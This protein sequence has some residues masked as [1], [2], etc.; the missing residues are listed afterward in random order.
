MRIINDMP[1]N[2]RVS[3]KDIAYIEVKKRIIEGRLRP[4]EPIVEE[5]I[6]NELGISRTP[7]REALQRLEFETLV[8]RQV[9]G[10]LRVAPVSVKEVN[11]IFHV[12]SRLE[13]IA[14]AEATKNAT[15]EDFQKLSNIILMIKETQGDRAVNDILYY[16]GQFHTYIYEMSKNKT[17]SNLLYQLN[18]HIHRYRHLIPVTNLGKILKTGEEH[19]HI[20]DFMAKG[21]KEGAESAM[22][23]HILSS[24]DQVIESVKAYENIE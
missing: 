11:E 20:L 17:V 22:V 16:G 24:L 23:G 2:R 6:S 12:R 7:L 4:G 3:T 10:R 9:N 18:D 5:T 14:V 21:D 8:V 1:Q 15:E 19:Q 13:G